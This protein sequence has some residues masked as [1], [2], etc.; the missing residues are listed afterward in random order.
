MNLDDIGIEHAGVAYAAYLGWTSDTSD[1]VGACCMWAVISVVL[2]A[3]V[4]P[5]AFGVIL[6]PL[7]SWSVNLFYD[8]DIMGGIIIFSI[9]LIAGAFEF[10]YAMRVL[11]DI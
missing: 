7:F 5:L 3:F 10:I 1:A 6:I 4:G 11:L 9:T 2:A 8:G